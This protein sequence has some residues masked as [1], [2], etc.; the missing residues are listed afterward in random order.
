MLMVNNNCATG[1]I[2]PYQPSVAKP[3]NKERAMHLFR[4]MGFGANA[5]RIEQALM[6]DPG[7]IVDQVIDE[8]INLPLSPEPEW[9]FWNVNDYTDFDAQREEQLISWVVNWV[10]DMA[11]KGFR[12]KL[13]LFWHNHFVTKFEAYICTSHMYQYHKILQENALGNFKTFV[14]EIGKTPAMLVFLN[15]VQNS[16]IEPNENYARELYELFTLGRDNGYTQKDIEETARALTGWVG[17]FAL[18]GPIGFLPVAHDTGEKTIFGQTGNWGY[19]D[20]HNIL[21]EQK[22]DLVAKFICTKIYH[23]FVHPQVDE[24]FVEELAATFKNNDFA[25]APVFKQLFKSDHFFDDYVIGTQVKS[26]TDLTISLINEGGFVYDDELIQAVTFF[27]YQLGQE[28][29]NPVDVAG[30]PG[31]RS[32][33]TSSTIT[34]RWQIVTAYAFW[35]FENNPDLLVKLAKDLNGGFSNDAALVTQNI[36]DHFIPNGFNTPD[37]YDKA[38]AVF[39]WEI[40]QNYFDEGLWN[41]EWDTVSVQ[42]AVL[43]D[44]L[45]RLPEFQ[46]Q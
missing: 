1:T 36:V 27:I 41:L 13:A 6:Q 26:P 15:G 30:W 18:C 45:G 46:L 42:V 40:P 21:F 39:K 28:L 19:D 10:K 33:I 43:I 9:A 35:M 24:A 17:F 22:G 32:W 20:V 16:L 29:F 23:H 12:E 5:E 37:A 2:A 7:Q 25:I 14:S 8:A 11:E 34:A 3:W 38:T 44:Y 4:R 31:N